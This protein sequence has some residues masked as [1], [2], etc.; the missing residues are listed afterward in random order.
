MSLP[1][2]MST[3]KLLRPL[4]FVLL[5]A[6]IAACAG[7]EGGKQATVDPH[8]GVETAH[9]ANA[10]QR[11]PT[12]IVIPG[13]V[14]FPQEA[15]VSPLAEQLADFAEAE[16]GRANFRVLERADFGSLQKDFAR[17]FASKDD[18]L[19][20][21]LLHKG[22]Y[23]AA[24]WVVRFDL[25]QAERQGDGWRLKLRYRIFNARTTAEVGSGSAEERFV[26]DAAGQRAAAW[27]KALVSKAVAEM[28]QQYKG[29]IGNVGERLP[30][31]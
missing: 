22:S 24:R 7:P 3:V 17:A 6:G 14:N 16:L 29:N 26:A 1:I 28:D 21:R 12:L 30:A 9:Y 25:T 5:L 10:A 4:P 18:R 15:A 31:G 20:S 13:E 23:R 8:P 19:A 27:M 11:G 2:A